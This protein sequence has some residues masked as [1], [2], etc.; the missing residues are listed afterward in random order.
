[1]DEVT[2]MSFF[3]LFLNQIAYVEG[4]K[5]VNNPQIT[6]IGESY[7]YETRVHHYTTHS[8]GRTHHHTTTRRVKVV[9]N[10]ARESVLYSQCEDASTGFSILQ[11]SAVKFY[12]MKTF[13]CADVATQM[14]VNQQQQIFIATNKPRDRYFSFRI[15]LDLM[16]Y[17]QYLLGVRTAK[18]CCFS[19]ECFTGSAILG[20]ASCYTCWFES[21]CVNQ[22]YYFA[23]KIR[24]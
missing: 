1:M 16:E 21:Q 17:N 20:F 12:F 23:K 11:G 18:P 22:E 3:S 19:Y 4:M 6:L 24:K 9:T 15:A 14:A 2:G 13:F 7:H 5:R 8:K 10:I